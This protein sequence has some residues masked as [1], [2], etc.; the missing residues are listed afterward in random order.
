VGGLALVCLTTVPLV[1]RW[2][3]S[4]ENL[5]VGV[6]V[7]AAAVLGG[8]LARVLGRRRARAVARAAQ[9]EH[10]LQQVVDVAVNA[11]RSSM[12]RDLHDVVSHAIGLIAVQAAA[13]EMIWDTDRPGAL[14]A[15]DLVRA[16]ATETLA[17]IDRLLP[18]DR[19]TAK[20]PTDLGALVD[21]I[22]AAGASVR[23]EMRGEPDPETMR[24]AYRVVQEALTNVVRHASGAAAVVRVVVASGETTIEV[25][26]DGPGSTGTVPRGYGLVGLGERVTLAGGTLTTGPGPDG[27]GF[28]VLAS[29]PAPTPEVVA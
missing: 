23:L 25:L 16:T 15:V 10:E 20:T 19:S 14:R 9:R 17:D 4:P 1:L 5:A 2:V 27:H 28:R 21:R 11:E 24:V 3:G 12:A 26:D 13:A 8:L 18:G 6:V 22:R 29:V 7:D